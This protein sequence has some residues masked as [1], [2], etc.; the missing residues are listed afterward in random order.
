MPKYT[1][2]KS[3]VIHAPIERVY[4]HVRDF[5]KWPQWSPWLILEPECRLRFADDGKGYSWHGN[6]VGSGEMEIVKEDHPNAIHYRLA[7]FSPWKAVSSV[8]HTFRQRAEGT[9]TEI[10]W[11]MEGS[12]PLFLFWMKPMMR[13]MLGLDFL[14]GLGMLEDL[15]ET[16]TVPSRLDFIGAASYSGC[17]YVGVRNSCAIAG[18][19]PSMES[20]L[21]KLK[22]WLDESGL[23]PGGAPFSIYHR[24]AASKGETD[25]TI[26]F[27]FVETPPSLPLEFKKGEIPACDVYTIKHT[28]PYRH[29]GNAW[30]AGMYRERN[31]VFRHKRGIDPFEIY[32]NEPGRVADSDLVTVVH[33]PMVL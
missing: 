27:P 19:G 1:V 12:L 13:G 33:F 28:G 2:E 4:E 18:I 20:D 16:G 7:F 32:E 22:A 3:L 30:T 24:W 15:V 26:G 23:K 10:T 25:Y 6:F 31:K 5:R 9:K 11:A 14:R 17:H 8:Q 21:A 29:L